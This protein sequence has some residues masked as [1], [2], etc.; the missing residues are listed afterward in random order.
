MVRPKAIAKKLE[1]TNGT[2]IKKKPSSIKTLPSSGACSGGI[3]KTHKYRPGTVALR[4][5]RKFQRT[6]ENIIPKAP[7]KRLVREVCQEFRNDIRWQASAID[8]MQEA[9]E[10]Y[11]TSL[12]GDSQ[13]C[14]VHAK[15]I[16]IQ[17][18]DLALARRI[19]M[20]E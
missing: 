17:S 2:T 20:G 1:S 3:T 11:L 13:L 12:F 14:A 6:T 5:I 19:R 4:E 18:E 16:T 10:Q 8:A 7:F 15:R 9:A